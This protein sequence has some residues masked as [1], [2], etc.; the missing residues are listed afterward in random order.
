[1]DGILYTTGPRGLTI[2]NENGEELHVIEFEE[3]ITNLEWGGENS[4]HLFI[5]GS[6]HVYRLPMNVTGNKKR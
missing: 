4:D 2:L 1:M 6:D 5:T 3:Q